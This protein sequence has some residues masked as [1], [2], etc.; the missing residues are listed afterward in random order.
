MSLKVHAHNFSAEVIAIL[1]DLFLEICKQL[2][3]CCFSLTSV[4]K[5]SIRKISPKGY[6]V[7]GAEAVPGGLKPLFFLW[8]PLE[9]Q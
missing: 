5:N 1:V 2:G 7:D 8:S 4:Q 3:A 9:L 6:E